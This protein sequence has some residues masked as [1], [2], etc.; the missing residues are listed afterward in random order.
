MRGG[1]AEAQ[2]QARPLG[3][4]VPLD[5]L[6]QARLVK[7]DVEGAEW[8]VMQCLR[9][10]LPVLAADAQV[11]IEVTP[12]ALE[13]LGGSLHALVDLF[14]A[15]GFEVWEIANPYTIEPYLAPVPADPVPL[16]RRDFKVA[17]LLFR[18]PVT[19]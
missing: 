10:V 13:T 18:R 9:D 7:I 14:A 2:V 3:A 5:E 4:V 12:V 17:D 15:A 11:L 19:E 16:Q 8:L 6:R 1:V